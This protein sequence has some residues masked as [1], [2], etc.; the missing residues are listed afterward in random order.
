M[1]SDSVVFPEREGH[2]SRRCYSSQF[3]CVTQEKRF[4]FFFF[5]FVLL[6][7]DVQIIFDAVPISHSSNS[8][9]FFIY[10]Y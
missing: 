2:L 3:L 5:F 4:F 7:K 10:I 8:P 1:G 9:L 6:L